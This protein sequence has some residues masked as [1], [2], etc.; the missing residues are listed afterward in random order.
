MKHSQ[1]R[2]S[3]EHSRPGIAH[4]LTNAPT[5]LGF[6]AMNLAFSTRAFGRTKQA[7]TQPLDCVLFQ[8]KALRT[9]FAIV[10]G[11]M[12]AAVDSHHCFKRSFLAVYS[13]STCGHACLNFSVAHNHPS[14]CGFVTNPARFSE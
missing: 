9:Q 5:H 14:S 8:L 1:K 10:V 4:H 2:V 3:G 12:A 7:F 11:V 13:G 6:I